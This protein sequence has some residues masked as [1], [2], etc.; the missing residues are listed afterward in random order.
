MSRDLPQGGRRGSFAGGDGR[1]AAEVLP[2]ASETCSIRRRMG[3]PTFF[4]WAFSSGAAERTEALGEA[5]GAVLAPGH[6]VGLVGELG[7]GKTCFVRG[8]ARGAGVAEGAGVASPTFTL[9]N[10]YSG[11]ILI[12]HIDLYRVGEAAELVELGVEHYLGGQGACLVEWFDRFAEDLGRDRSLQVHFA[13]T[14]DHD[15]CLEARATDETHARLAQAWVAR[16]PAA[17]E[18]SAR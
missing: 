8:V 2:A 10:E 6:V 17:A 18:G 11:R 12:A 7:A 3:E 13:I 9:I 4:T 14:G 15:R 1:A 5:L 16:V